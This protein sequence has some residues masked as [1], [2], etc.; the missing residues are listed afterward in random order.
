MNKNF[1]YLKVIII[2]LFLVFT[3]IYSIGSVSAATEC[4]D[5]LDNDRNGFIDYPEDPGCSGATD[6][7]E[8]PDFPVMYLPQMPLCIGNFGTIIKVNSGDTCTLCNWA[9]GV[10]RDNVPEHYSYV[11]PPSGSFYDGNALDW[12]W[13]WIQSPAYIEWDLNQVTNILR[14]FPSQDH[15]AYI[16]ESNKFNVKV[17]S[18]RITWT[19]VTAT[20]TYV[21]DINNIRTH[22]GVIDF[23]SIIP[24]RY[25]RITP[26][27]LGGADLEIDAVRAC[28]HCTTHASKRCVGNAVYWFDSCGNQEGQFQACT[29]GQACQNTQCVDIV[30]TT[31]AN[32]GTNEYVGSPFCQSGN[33][34]QNF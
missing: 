31:N 19:S 34:Y 29:S 13:I 28:Q 11:N 5:C 30:C 18:D 15:G 17:S 12:Y 26:N 6:T 33:I 27:L 25:V 14:V 20:Q 22:D 10:H 21:D 8:S 2:A 23:T 32:C 16:N 1:I 4:S 9:R 7:E 3:G 24:F